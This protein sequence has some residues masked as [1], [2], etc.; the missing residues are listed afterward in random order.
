MEESFVGA[1]DAG[2]PPAGP[3]R[4]LLGKGTDHYYEIAIYLPD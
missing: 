2:L 4:E 1:V 3:V